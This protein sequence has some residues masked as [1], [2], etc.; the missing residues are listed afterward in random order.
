MAFEAID[1]KQWV[2]SQEVQ[3]LMGVPI[4]IIERKDDYFLFT[5]KSV[6]VIG[7]A[8]YLF[9][10]NYGSEIDS[11]DVIIRMNRA[12]MLYTAFDAQLTHGSRTDV[13]CMWRHTEYENVHVDQP[14]FVAQMAWFD[15]PPKDSS[16][17][18]IEN[19]PL[20]KRLLPH[21]PSTGLMVLDWVSKFQTKSVSVYG[22]DWKATPTFTNTTNKREDISIHDFTKEREMCYNT[23]SQF[24][25]KE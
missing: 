9:T 15:Q 20:L 16:V 25:F 8:Q 22:F 2:G 21:Y 10:K 6:A 11:H 24:T 23:Y 13:W 18:V 1:I 7:N 17:R 19:E 12:A 5:G 4:M 14:P 3:I